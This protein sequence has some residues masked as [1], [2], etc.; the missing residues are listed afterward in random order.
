M[1]R[2]ILFK[3][4]LVVLLVAAALYSLYPTFQLSGLQK[5]ETQLVGQINHVSGLS[6]AD[7]E[8]AMASGDLENQLRA[9]VKS[10]DQDK[11]LALADQL[12][13]LNAR[14]AKVEGKAIHRGLDLQGGTYMNR[15]AFHLGNA[16]RKSTRLNSSHRT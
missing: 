5:Q 15:L 7:I 11:A 3:I 10:G 14:I 16:D 6:A 2:K 9:I 8:G 4:V 12:I 13:K 1:Q